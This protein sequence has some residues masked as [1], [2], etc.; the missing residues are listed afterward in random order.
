MADVVIDPEYGER[1]LAAELAA[2]EAAGGLVAPPDPMAVGGPVQIAEVDWWDTTR[3]ELSRVEAFE[4]EQWAGVDQDAAERDM[5]AERAPAWVGLAPGGELA[6]AL[7]TVRPQTESPIG[8]I[9]VMKAAARLSAWAEAVKLAAIAG[10]YRQ[11]QAQAVDIP[12]PRELDAQGR[13]SDPLRS[14]AAEIAAAL[15][16]A[17][18][19]ATSHLDTALRL[20]STLTA[21]HTALRCGAITLSKALAIADATNPLPPAA[22][23]AVQHRVLPRAAGQTHAGLRAALRRAVAAADTRDQAARHRDATRNR[24]CRIVPLAD[25]MAGLW[26]THT[27]DKIQQLYTVVRALAALAK[28]PTATTDTDGTRDGSTTAEL[29]VGADGPDATD[30]DGTETSATVDIQAD[31]STPNEASP[32]STASDA[33]PDA[34]TKVDIG[35][36]PEMDPS[37]GPKLEARADTAPEVRPGPDP[38]VSTITDDPQAGA[39]TASGAVTTPRAEA[40]TSPEAGATTAAASNTATA[41]RAGTADRPEADT[42]RAASAPGRNTEPAA[43]GALAPAPDSARG[44]PQTP[45][46]AANTRSTAKD[47]RTAEQR[48][49]DVVV[50]L[51]AHILSNGL[52]WLG[53]R[54][55]D[56][57]KRRPHIEVTIPITTLMELNDDPCELTGYGPIT[58]DMARRIAADG[59]WRR[60]LTDPTNGAVLEAATTRHD[61]GTAVTETLLARHPVCDWTGCNQPARD[62][63]RDH[64]TPYKHTGTT[65]LAGLTIYCQYHHVI[66][67]TPAWGWKATNNPDG[68]TTLT[69]PT[70]HRYTTTPPAR[71]PITT[72]PQPPKP[73]EP[74]PF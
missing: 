6:A 37:A 71:G 29:A 4:W 34:A 65:T 44:A 15:R 50:D 67:D 70:G 55:P 28:R 17:P 53:R 59:T 47:T 52:D 25:G 9:E 18:A 35:T 19:T 36:T 66:K 7:E 69:S 2:R 3:Y 33:A 58:A 41:P 74:P 40:V 20:T 1:G 49:A 46:S 5:L 23:R 21:T 73:P 31:S 39:R 22:Q 60:L 72:P 57:H 8:L 26:I 14:A 16:L 63:D 61:P 30:A 10:F 32:T 51:F 45:A 13:P 54:L 24:E 43:T 11:R 42:T 64:T 62:C 68:S 48:R 12:R 27:A 38:R 56:Q